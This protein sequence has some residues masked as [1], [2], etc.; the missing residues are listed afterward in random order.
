MA[1]ALSEAQV[2]RTEIWANENNSRWLKLQF[3]APIEEKEIAC[4]DF[5]G[6]V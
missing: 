6:Y 2:T 4:N 3:P 5:F 1:A